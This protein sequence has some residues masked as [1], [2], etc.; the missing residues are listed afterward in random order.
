MLCQLESPYIKCKI[1]SVIWTRQLDIS[2]NPEQILPR[3]L[4]R[5]EVGFCLYKSTSKQIRVHGWSYTEWLAITFFWVFWAL[6]HKQCYKHLMHR[7]Q[8]RSLMRA[9]C[10]HDGE[11]QI[12]GL[13]NHPDFSG[14]GEM[15]GLLR[16]D[17]GRDSKY[18]LI[19]AAHLLCEMPCQIK[20]QQH[21]PCRD[22][23]LPESVP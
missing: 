11:F 4:E 1:H 22:L 17:Y 5:N 3:E 7:C 14:I 23:N 10:S 8:I 15:S 19:S 13:V 20:V 12:S 16:I 21:Y 18:L 2:L 9:R 6:T